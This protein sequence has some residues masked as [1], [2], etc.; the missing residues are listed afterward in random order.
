[1]KSLEK[2]RFGTDLHAKVLRR[3]V[4]RKDFSQEKMAGRREK[5]EKDDQDFTLYVKERE[6]DSLRQLE[7]ERGVKQFVDIEVPMTYAMVMTAH[8]YLSTVF[9]SRNPVFQYSGRHGEGEMNVLAVES[10]IDYQV[11][12][13]NNLPPQYIWLL[14]VLKYG[15]GI[16]WDYWHND[17]R[18]VSRLEERPLTVGG[19][20][21]PGRTVLEKVTRRVPG[22]EGNKLLNVRPY[23]H[24]PDP[25]VSISDPQSGEFVGRLVELSWNTLTRRKITG[26]YINVD[27]LKNRMKARKQTAESGE[28]FRFS[29][30]G[31]EEVPEGGNSPASMMDGISGF[32][33]V[34]EIIPKEWELGSTEHPEKWVFAVADDA[35]V[36]EARP[37]GMYH[38]EFP[39]P[40]IESEFDPYKLFKISMFERG[41]PLND[42]M[43]WLFNTHFYNVRKSLNGE[44]IFDPSRLNAADILSKEPGKRIRVKPVGYGQDV[45]TMLQTVSGGADLTGTHIRDT[46]VVGTLLQRTLGVNENI[47]GALSSGGRKTATEVRTASSSSVN[48]MRTL[49]EYISALGYAPLSQRLVQ[50]T[51]QLYTGEQKFRIAGDTVNSPEGFMEITPE[52]ISG[53]YDYVAVDGTLPLDRF[54]VVNMWGSLLSQIQRMPQIMAQYDMGKIFEWVAQLGG[55]KN[56]RQFRLNVV[57]PEELAAQ[58][59]GGNVVSAGELDGAGRRGNPQAAA[60]ASPGGATQVQIPR[61]V[62]GVGRSG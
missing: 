18:Q 59:A 22:Y 46:D 40:V 62:P 25:R 42:T 10:L 32:E 48:R 34:V 20:E 36:I 33:M 50:S 3:L 5:W 11:N 58:A 17:S 41:R 61:Q 16:L 45:R 31:T 4:E 49:A 44:I 14:D 15:V 39:V 53:F 2:I 27:A 38:D 35:V 12:V 24:L 28:G 60:G 26:Q 51:Q 6:T 7:K 8:T 54:A 56:I 19:V 9:L 23:D 21:V 1:M 47:M 13:G 29:P 37:S 30:L 43:N 52:T 55:I 57:P